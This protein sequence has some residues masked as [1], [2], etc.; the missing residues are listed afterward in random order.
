MCCVIVFEQLCSF[1]F[2]SIVILLQIGVG[3]AL[4]I[5]LYILPLL[6]NL[7]K[8]LINLK[9]LVHIYD[10]CIVKIII[11]ILLLIFL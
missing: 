8:N 3:E 1:G 9:N 7:L 10:N 2:D 5:F 4:E 11:Y 6:L